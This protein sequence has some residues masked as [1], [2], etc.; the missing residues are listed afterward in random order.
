MFFTLD[1]GDRLYLD[2]YGVSTPAPG[3]A[4]PWSASTASAAAATSSPDWARR[5]SRRPPGGRHVLCPDLP[6]S[7]FS[8]RGDRPITF[9]R[10]ADAVVQLI[11]RKTT[12]PGRAAG[13]LDGDDHRPA[14]LRPHPGSHRLAALRRRPARAAPRGPGPPARPR[15]PGPH[16][17][18]CPPSPRPSC[19]SSSPAGPWTR[20]RTRW[21]C[22]SACSPTA[23]RRATR[24]RPWPWPTPPRSDVVARVRV[25]CLCV[26]G[27]EDRYAPPAA[28]RAF[29]DSIPGAT[30]QE[31]PGCGHMPFF[32]DPDGFNRVSRR[33]SVGER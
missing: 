9:D 5:C 16:Q 15:R 1:N 23:T 4:P 29:A 32:E 27:T 31:L 12:R 19:P 11:E 6:G 14:G 22:S 8:P 28:V 7:G 21:R 25:P 30:Y 2:E 17:P 13:P 3:T 20:S 24:R 33:L 26:T 10:F 18:A